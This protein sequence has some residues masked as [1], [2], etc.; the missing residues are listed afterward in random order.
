MADSILVVVEQR[1]GKLNRVSFETLRG[2][3]LIAGET[4]WTLE[5]AVVG[6]GASLGG[7]AAEVAKAMRSAILEFQQKPHMAKA[8]LESSAQP[9]FAQASAG[10]PAVV[11]DLSAA[12]SAKGDYASVSRTARS[13]SDSLNGLASQRQPLSS[14]KRSASVP[15]TS[16]VTKMTRFRSAGATVASSR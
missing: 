8:T 13:K 1:E 16:P 10:K 15:A 7:I 11:V 5:A 9:A 14:R 4:G 12:A 3:Q 2:A 6:A